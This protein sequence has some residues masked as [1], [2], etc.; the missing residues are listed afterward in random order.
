MTTPLIE[1]RHISKAFPGVQALKDVSLAAYGSEVHMC[2]KWE[3][4][5]KD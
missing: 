1:M 3:S 5:V 2:P 4:I